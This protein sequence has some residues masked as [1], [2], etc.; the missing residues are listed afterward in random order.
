M[1]GV[2]FVA[3]KIAKERKGRDVYVIG[4][5]NVGKSAF[6]RAMLREMSRLEGMNYDPAAQGNG[7]YLP[8]ESAMPGTTLGIIPLRAFK[9]GGCLFGE[10]LAL[11]SAKD[12]V[13]ADEESRLS[14]GV[15]QDTPSCKLVN[16]LFFPVHI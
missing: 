3:S 9:S 7:R 12:L 13:G 15:L 1:T 16:S 10:M 4:A 2:P 14:K 11:V 5:A 6:V 8:V